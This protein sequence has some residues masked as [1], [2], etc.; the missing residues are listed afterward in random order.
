[1][2]TP[3]PQTDKRSLRRDLVIAACCGV[4]VAAMVGAA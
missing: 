2:T 4:F 1:M 3:S